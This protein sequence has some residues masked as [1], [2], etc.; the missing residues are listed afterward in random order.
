VANSNY[1]D[2][3]TDYMSRVNYRIRKEIKN[4]KLE[5]SQESKNIKLKDENAAQRKIQ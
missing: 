5:I 3:K 1:F 2:V 4:G